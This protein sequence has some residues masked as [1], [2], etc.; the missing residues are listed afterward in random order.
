MGIVDRVY[1]LIGILYK[2]AV[3]VS[4]HKPRLCWLSYHSVSL[5]SLSLSFLE[6]SHFLSSTKKNTLCSSDSLT[7]A[8]L[9][10]LLR[11]SV[12]K[13]S[14]SVQQRRRRQKKA[15]PLVILNILFLYYSLS[16]SLR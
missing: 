1:G 9:H 12:C 16:F 11:V 3:L 7:K 10:F 15:V 5:P 13:S 8:P 6:S 2:R 4:T 14:L